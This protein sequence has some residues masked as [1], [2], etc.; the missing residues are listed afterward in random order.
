MK[1]FMGPSAS[2][3][4]LDISS[5][6]IKLLELSRK[7]ARL[8][9]ENYGVEPLP[10][11]LIEEKSIRDI[12]RVGDVLKTLLQ[13]CRSRCRKGAVAIAGSGVITKT[14]QF[15]GNFSEED[16]EHQIRAE[17]EQ[18]IPYPLDEVAIDF[19][20]LRPN[21][22]D[23]QLVDVLL[24]A[25]RQENVDARVDALD[26]AGIE[27]VVVDIEPYVLERAFSLIEDQLPPQEEGLLV[28]LVDVGATTTTLSVFDN[29]ALVYTREQV[30]GGQQLT[31]EIQHRYGLSYEEAGLAKKR[32]GL[33]NDYVPDVLQPFKDNLVQQVSRSLQFFFSSSS[34]SQVDHL[35]LAGGTAG[36]SQLD[37]L[38]QAQLGIPCRIANPFADMTVSSKVNTRALNADAPALLIS[39]GLAMRGVKYG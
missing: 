24:A 21:A 18:H 1:I 3:L 35:I 6:S 12:A 4:G 34:Y 32:G 29:G 2:V 16:I 31:H 22:N 38:L 13:K 14:L 15:D 27:A 7:G 17:A 19:E 23:P 20:I 28:A 37:E 9:V 30:F 36:L 33:P 39:C 11:G 25:S 8:R 5:T 10:A 26:V